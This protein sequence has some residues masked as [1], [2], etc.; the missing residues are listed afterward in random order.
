MYVLFNFISRFEFLFA[1]IFVLE[2]ELFHNLPRLN[3]KKLFEVIHNDVFEMIY[4][5]VFNDIDIAP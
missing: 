2:K 4:S 5:D 1:L 3:Q